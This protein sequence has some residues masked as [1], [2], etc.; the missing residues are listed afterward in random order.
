MGQDGEVDGRD[1]IE[2]KGW[3]VA[4]SVAFGLEGD[5][6]SY[7]Y[8]LHTEQDNIPDGGVTT[9]G[10][11]GFYNANF[12]VTNPT[13][14]APGVIPAPVDSETYYGYRS[15]FEQTTGTMFT[16]RFEHDFS[17]NV[18]LRNSTRIGRLEQFYVLTGVNAVNVPNPIRIA[19]R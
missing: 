11:D 4:P 16:A 14:T 5:T 2:R 10:Q 8:L 19:G 7:F 12:D 1:F 18:S 9:L 3:A 13:A 17:E 6:R 15:D